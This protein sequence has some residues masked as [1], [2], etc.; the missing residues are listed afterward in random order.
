[1]SLC[2][3]RW[4]RFAV[5]RHTT[6]R[7]T[8]PRAVPAAETK[9]IVRVS[10]VRRA[11]AKGRRTR[12]TAVG[13]RTRYVEPPARADKNWPRDAVS[14]EHHAVVSE[15]GAES[16]RNGAPRLARHS[17]WHRASA[18]ALR[19]S[20]A[21]FAAAAAAGAPVKPR[22]NNPGGQRPRRNLR[23]RGERENIIIIAIRAR[24]RAAA[25]FAKACSST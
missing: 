21:Y 2:G 1:M 17:C 8:E 15:R 19:R 20:R 14:R 4:N 24:A 3:V 22:E 12:R 13:V 23:A 5:E 16:M 10:L 25:D 18:S 6:Q 9:K 11:A 7:D